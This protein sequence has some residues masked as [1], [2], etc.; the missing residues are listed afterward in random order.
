MKYGKKTIVLSSILV[1]FVIGIHSLSQSQKPNLD[2]VPK[3]KQDGRP[4]P[5]LFYTNVPEHPFDIIM[6][7]PT[8]SSVTLSILTYQDM[9][10]YC[11]YGTEQ[12][13]YSYQTKQTH[14]VKGEPVEMELNQLQPNTRYYYRFC[15]CKFDSGEYQK[16]AE[17]MFHTQRTP[18]STFTITVQ[19]DSHLDQNTNTDLYAKTLANVLSDSPDFHID[20][21]DTF[22]TDKYG[23]DYKESFKQY[24]AQRYYFGLLCHSTP[25]FLGLGNHDGESGRRLDGTK[26]N[27]SVWAS[28]VRKRFYPNPSPDGFYTGNDTEEPFVG[29][30]ED[31]YAWNWGD[32][33]F[34]VLDPYWYTES[35]SDHP[36]DRTLGRK[37]Y[38]WLK[39]TLENSQARFKFVFIHHLVGGADK[40]GKSRGGAEVAKYFEWGGSNS[41]G[42]KGF[43]QHRSGWE[44]PIHELLVQHNVSVVFH[45]HDHF[46]AKQD[47]DG[48]VY[49]LVPQPGQRKY[50]NIQSAVEYGYIHGKL[51]NGPGHIRIRVAPK[52]VTIDYVRA[53]L[54]QDIREGHTNGEIAYS[55]ILK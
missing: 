38:S 13:V 1:F 36:W 25:L 10:G 42:S 30:P 12:G 35:K 24:L 4:K 32:A 55:Y 43:Q 49:Q 26:D 18:G 14:Y 47:L 6:G 3:R 52:S 46:F 44:K 23:V 15:F 16:S 33:L 37:Q 22:M 28:T 48:I 40:N 2:S 54:P 21:G 29:F 27:M 31:Y 39:H 11:Q 53:Y 20:L 7:R 50:D 17:F 34:V 5:G 41:D 45:G 51:V 19:A 9:E 8:K